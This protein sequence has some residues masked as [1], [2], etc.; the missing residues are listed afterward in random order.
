V[1][2][3]TKQ[4]EVCKGKTV[5]KVECESYEKLKMIFDDGTSLIVELDYGKLDIILNGKEL[6]EH[7]EGET[8]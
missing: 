6:Y 2:N 8:K 4:L 5:A 1:S 3:I 7:Y